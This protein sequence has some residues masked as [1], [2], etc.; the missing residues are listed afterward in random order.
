MTATR[1]DLP[2]EDGART[3]QA[4]HKKFVKS[5][6]PG[7]WVI[8]A[9]ALVVFSLLGV[10]IYN[11]VNSRDDATK[12]SNRTL[13]LSSQIQQACSSGGIP[14]QY[15]TLCADADQAKREVLAERGPEG[16][17]GDE[18]P[19]G[20]QG[21]PGLNGEDGQPGDPGADG[22]DGSDGANGS[23]GSDGETI[24]G[25]EGPQGDR[26][27]EGPQGPV[28]P[29]GPPP[30]SWTEIRQDGSVKTCERVADFNPEAPQYVCTTS[31]AS[32]PSGETIS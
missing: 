11:S 6:E 22:S 27:P 7:K 30:V 1:L 18:G 12:S 28:G 24:R 8:I 5:I 13:D 26:G 16:P 17:E 4:R 25:P 14:M 15:A 31:A 19:R 2:P 10:L 21:I 32:D 29:A 3:G 9:L 20:P 23:N